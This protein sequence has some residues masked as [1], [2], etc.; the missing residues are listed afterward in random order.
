MPLIRLP[1]SDQSQSARSSDEA[2]V[3]GD[4][5]LYLVGRIQVE[6]I[7]E[8][9][10][11]LGAVERLGQSIWRLDAH[12]WQPRKGTQRCMDAFRRKPVGAPKHPFGFEENGKGDE[13]LVALQES[14][15][16]G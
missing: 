3:K 4:K 14:S 9:E 13:H 16:P 6:G 2:C 8:V 1:D 15:R 5:S 7:S 12:L 10:A 11:C